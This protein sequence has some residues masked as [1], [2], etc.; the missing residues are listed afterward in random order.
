M[1]LTIRYSLVAL[2]LSDEGSNFRHSCD[3]FSSQRTSFGDVDRAYSDYRA[4]IDSELL[5][6]HSTLSPSGRS[7][8]L[9]AFF[10]EAKGEAIEE[11][12]EILVDEVI[13]AAIPFWKLGL[14]LFYRLVKGEF[15]TE[16]KLRLARE[17]NSTNIVGEIQRLQ[18]ENEKLS[19]TLIPDSTVSVDGIDSGVDICVTGSNNSS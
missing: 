15:P 12:V 7:V 10:D 16:R 13:G 8:G 19:G 14:A 9:R 5:R 11:G 6:Q 17:A 18:R 3:L 2:S 4:S 1:R